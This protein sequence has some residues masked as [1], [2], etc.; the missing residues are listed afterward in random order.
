VRVTT[1]HALD[2]RVTAVT[3]SPSLPSTPSRCA[4]RWKASTVGYGLAAPSSRQRPADAMVG[5]GGEE[6]AQFCLIDEL[7]VI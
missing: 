6:L 1:S 4:R 5:D 3:S 2:A 7:F